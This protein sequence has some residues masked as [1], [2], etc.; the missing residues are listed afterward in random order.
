[1]SNE[2]I[3]IDSINLIQQGPL[4]NHDENINLYFIWL[5]NYDCI[6]KRCASLLFCLAASYT[7]LC[8]ITSSAAPVILAQA[9]AWSSFGYALVEA[10]L[11]VRFPLCVLSIASFNLWSFPNTIVNF[12]DVTS[13]FWVILAVTIYI[14]PQ[15]KH[16]KMVLTIVNI[17]FAL[18]IVIIISTSLTHNV[19]EYY[20]NNLIII[21]GLIYALCGIN[22]ASY[23]ITNNTFLV[24][25]LC[26]TV[27]FTC[28]LMTIYE[29]QYW[30]TSVFHLLTA[31]SIEK[32]LTL[33]NQHTNIDISLKMLKCERF[34]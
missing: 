13:I 6:K 4:I 16:S 28:K 12:I 15:A 25:L 32:L 8:I 26:I 18:F 30:G 24:G 21:T 20:E 5:E 11:L 29:N 3:T 14:S 7:V 10:P 17:C 23:Y 22:M 2:I 31:L 34:V 1:M 33:Q 9:N 27:G 19:L